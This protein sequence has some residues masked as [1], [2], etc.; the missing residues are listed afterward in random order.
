M[1]SFLS[2]KDKKVNFNQLFTSPFSGERYRTITL[3]STFW[4]IDQIVYSG[5]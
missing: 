5:S 4:Q 1:P 3:F 2:V